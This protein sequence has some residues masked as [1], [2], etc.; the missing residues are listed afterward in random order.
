MLFLVIMHWILTEPLYKRSIMRVISR[1]MAAFL[2]VI[3][4]AFGAVAM[5]GCGGTSSS[6]SSAS[7]QSAA[8]SASG[9]EKSASASSA[10]SDSS[11]EQDDCYGDDLPAVKSK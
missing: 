10:N 1:S 3:S 4:M 9:S 5:V 6:T 2:L 7:A 8:A 11:D